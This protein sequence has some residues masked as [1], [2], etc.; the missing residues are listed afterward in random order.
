[1]LTAQSSP[2]TE[3]PSEAY[4]LCVKVAKLYYEDDL[5]QSE[6]AGQL[7]YS[8]VKV[9]R[10]LKRARE[11]GIVRISVE[12]PEDQNFDLE[13]A[14][15]ERYGLRDAVVTPSLEDE[16]AQYLALSAGATSWLNEHLGPGLRIGLGLGRTIS[17]LPLTFQP[18]KKG[19]YTFTEVVGAASDHSRGL[20]AYNITSRMAEIANSKAEFFYAP[21]YVSDPELKEKLLQEPS[22]AKALERARSCDMVLQSVGPADDTATLYVHGYL[23][24]AELNSIMEANAVGDALGRFFNA[25]GQHVPTLCDDRIIGPTLD[26]LRSLPWSVAIAGGSA[27]VPVIDAALKG[28]IFNVLVTDEQTARALLNGKLA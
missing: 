26:D 27:K 10:T 13:H 4:R 11:L 16:E 22:I 28:Q 5:T 9:N 24:K 14:L 21:T 18:D 17:H 3:I 25:E 15:L 7:G 12:V 23:S 1:M 8:R 6:I 20:E 19:D 2:S